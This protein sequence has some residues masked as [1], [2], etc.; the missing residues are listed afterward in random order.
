MATA[1][2]CGAPAAT[3]S[4]SS[5]AYRRSL[6]A[7]AR[8][9]PLPLELDR[10]EGDRLLDRRALRDG[11]LLVVPALHEQQGILR[12]GRDG[13]RDDVPALG[14]PL[15][16]TPA[17]GDH[18]STAEHRAGPSRQPCQEPN[19]PLDAAAALQALDEL[20]ASV[21]RFEQGPLPEAV[22]RLDELLGDLD[23]RD[24]VRHAEERQ[25][26]RGAGL[27]ELRRH[28]ADERARPEAEGRGVRPAE[29][30]RERARGRPVPE[31]DPGREH[32]LPAA[33]VRRRVGHLA[34]MDPANLALEVARDEHVEA[35]L[36]SRDELS[37]RERHLQRRLEEHPEEEKPGPGP[38]AQGRG[39]GVRHPLVSDTGSKHLPLAFRRSRRPREPRCSRE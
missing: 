36:R 31:P 10:E 5:A 38:P 13:G 23:E 8:D 9:R 22:L 39:T 14:A 21:D 1:A 34:R 37:H 17:R 19:E 20:A 25:P 18:R 24:P 15:P 30:G 11:R 33:Q 28:L 27:D 6:S 4:K 2:C 26:P 29:P 7:T 3:R 12:R 32:D 35:Q 16:V